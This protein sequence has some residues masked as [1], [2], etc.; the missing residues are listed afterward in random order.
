MADISHHHPRL[1]GYLCAIGSTAIWSVNFI[2]ARN[3]SGSIPPVSLAF[4]RWFI[5]LIVFLPFTLKPLIAE[6]QILKKHLFY[7]SIISL[8]GVTIFN[9]LLYLAAHTTS[10]INLSLISITFPVFV[11]ILSR[12]FFDEK[13]TLNKAIGIILVAIG[14][15][16]LIT[17]GAP[18]RL[19]HITFAVGDLWMLLASVIFAVYSVLLRKKPKQISIAVFQLSTFI[20]G[21][22]FLFP[23]F[24]WEYVT[25]PQGE[26]NIQNVFSILY[27]GIFASLIAYLLWNKSVMSIG[28]SK[29]GMVYYTIP[30]FS[31]VLAYFFL[32][33]G[34]GMIHIYSA[35]LIV[36]GILIA[37]YELKKNKPEK[38]RLKV[39]SQ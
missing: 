21:I 29:A 20:L 9:T 3:L 33:E 8:L 30:V 11:V 26:F 38:S 24:A 23:F 5:A 25:V 7:L 4:F 10:A 13:I 15:V 17:K 18:S 31:G 39:K 27:V 32:N 6:W 16:I 14:F 35:I 36:S 1:S 12:F 2:I 34:I 37:N 22:L 19:L 28:P